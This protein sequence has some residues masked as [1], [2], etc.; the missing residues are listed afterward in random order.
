MRVIQY[1]CPE[2]CHTPLNELKSSM[3]VIQYHASRA[4]LII[5]HGKTLKACYD[6]TTCTEGI[7][8]NH[9]LCRTPLIELQA[10]YDLTTCTEEI[11]GIIGLGQRFGAQQLKE[12]DNTEH[13]DRSFM[14]KRAMTATALGPVMQQVPFLAFLLPS[15]VST[16][17][18]G[19]GACVQ[20]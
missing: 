7:A 16:R 20:L 14:L 12:E 5:N 10:Y 15:A 13:A 2:L 6:L 19:G 8:S 9:E 11:I 3:R 18:K 4:S 17:C 1:H